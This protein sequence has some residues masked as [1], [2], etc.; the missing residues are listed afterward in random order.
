MNEFG[1]PDLPYVQA[2]PERLVA[3]NNRYA[4]EHAEPNSAVHF[5]LDDYRFEVV[6][7]KPER[8]V[9]RP[10]KVGMAL[11]PDFSMWREMPLVMQ[12]WQIYRSRWCG[13]WMWHHGIT[14][15]PTITWSGYQSY[16][17]AFQGVAP[18]S[19]VAISTVGVRKDSEAS[20]RH[21]VEAMV[22]QIGPSN[23]LVYG[24]MIPALENLDNL[25]FYPHNWRQ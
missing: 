25:V 24:R 9:S 12:Q 11:T 19:T 6:W 7:T 5:F 2:R 13:M 8:G 22:D 16:S 1:I 20:F 21:G 23:I 15:I 18:G 3:Y 10:A 17:F 4:C 14:V